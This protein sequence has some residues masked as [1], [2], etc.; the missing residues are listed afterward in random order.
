MT[1]LLSLKR[2]ILFTGIVTLL[3]WAHVA[4]DYFHGG[5]PT[6]YLLHSADLAGFSN[7]WGVIIIPVLTWFLLVRINKNI[8]DK[9][10]K[11][12]QQNTS[13]VVYRFLSALVFGILVSFFFAIGSDLPEYMMMGLIVL[14]FFV[15]LYR[16]E[17]FLGFVLG[18]AYTFGTVLPIIFGTIFI[19]LFLL[20]YKVLRA[21]VVYLMAKIT[22]GNSGS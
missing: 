14:S 22:S 4:W 12:G 9:S 7:W 3:S 8:N 16:T 20:T 11:E 5:V 17:H 1:E 19:L 21:S 15:P 2:R 18:M 10:D 6:H 13:Y